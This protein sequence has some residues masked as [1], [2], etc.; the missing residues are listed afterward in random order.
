V[1]ESGRHGARCFGTDW[2]SDFPLD[3]FDSAQPLAGGGITLNRV[4]N[5]PERPLHQVS[6][7]MQLAP[8][9]F[10]FRWEHEATF[11]AHADG[12]IAV[13]PGQAWRGSLPIA[14]YSTVAATMLAWRGMLPMH[15]SSVVIEDR[16]WLIGGAGGA[17]KSTLTAELV[18]AGAQ[19]LADDLTVLRIAEGGARVTRGRPTIRLYPDVA[20]LIDCS[21]IRPQPDDERG[22]LLACPRQRAPDRDYPIGGILVLEETGGVA[23]EGTERVNLLARS[24]FRPRI[25]AR[26]PAGAQIAL[27]LGE[28][29]RTHRVLAM[30]ML[31]FPNAAQREKRLEQVRTLV[32]EGSGG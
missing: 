12:F 19:F 8:D 23:P 29:A 20:A 25:I 17:G 24:L 31:Q 32:G 18:A 15:M 4:G 16:A 26:S 6:P 30:P 2:R 28:L 3:Q 9:G 13:L 11:D 10:R 22:K 14:F 27:Q 21:E 5:L 1:S 7:R